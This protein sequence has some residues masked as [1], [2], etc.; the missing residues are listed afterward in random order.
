[1]GLLREF[2][3]HGIYLGGLVSCFLVKMNGVYGFVCCACNIDG[4]ASR[5]RVGCWMIWVVINWSVCELG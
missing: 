5:C 3:L 2:T 4:A 1:M